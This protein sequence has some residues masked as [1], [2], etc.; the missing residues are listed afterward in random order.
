MALEINPIA[1]NISGKQSHK[2]DKN[3]AEVFHSTDAS[4]ET[5]VLNADVPVLLDFWAHCQKIN[6]RILLIKRFNPSLL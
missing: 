1:P 5:D 3:M 6:W 4:F 2:K